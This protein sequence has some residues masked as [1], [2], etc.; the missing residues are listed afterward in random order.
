MTNRID[1]ICFRGYGGGVSLYE[2]NAGDATVLRS[3]PYQHELTNAGQARVVTTGRLYALGE[4]VYPVPVRL[5]ASEPT[6]FPP[7]ALDEAAWV[8]PY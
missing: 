5:P 3:S 2:P 7:Y 8:A 1:L 4:R 6:S